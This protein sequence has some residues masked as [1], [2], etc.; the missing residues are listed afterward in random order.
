MLCERL[1]EG[2][3]WQETA[4]MSAA[5]LMKLDGGAGWRHP[6]PTGLYE[7]AGHARPIWARRMSWVRDGKIEYACHPWP[8]QETCAAQDLRGEGV[9]GRWGLGNVRSG[10]GEKKH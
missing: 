7:Q 4:G 9:S 3:T 8:D 1:Q 6:I 5:A 10:L 2:M